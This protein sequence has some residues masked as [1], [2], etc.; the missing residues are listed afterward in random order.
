MERRR[1]S[2]TDNLGTNPRYVPAL[3]SSTY[4]SN[5]RYRIRRPSL[6]VQ[7]REPERI[8]LGDKLRELRV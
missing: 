4:Q 1:T 5:F 8:L 6:L 7:G 3:R 2:G